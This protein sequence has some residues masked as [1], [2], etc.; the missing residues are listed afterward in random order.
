MPLSAEDTKVADELSRLVRMGSKIKRKTL[1]NHVYVDLIEFHHFEM[2]AENILE[3]GFGANSIHYKRFLGAC[4][5][6]PYPNRSQKQFYVYMI[7]IQ[8][9]ILKATLDNLKKG[10]TK[11]LFYEREMIVFSDLLDQAYVFLENQNTFLAAGVYGRIVLE[12]AIR[13]FAK[14][15]LRESYNPEMKFDQIIIKL[16]DGGFILKTFEERLRSYYTIGSDAAHNSED[17][18]KVSKKELNNFST[19]IKDNVLTLN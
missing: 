17:F 13:E 6:I 5:F 3:I 11:D 16:R 8:I 7:D 18:K 1:D 10:L 2:S 4:K 14:L 12:T 15:K 9:G 19:F